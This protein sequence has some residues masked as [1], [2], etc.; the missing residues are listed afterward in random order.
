MIKC[1]RCNLWRWRL[2]IIR[3]SRIRIERAISGKSDGITTRPPTP[4]N[5]PLAAMH[6]VSQ[7]TECNFW[8]DPSRR[9][10]RPS[11]PI[12]HRRHRHQRYWQQNQVATSPWARPA[13]FHFRPQI[14]FQLGRSI[15]DEK[16]G[17]RM[18]VEK[19]SY[20]DFGVPVHQA[21]KSAPEFYFP[22]IRKQVTDQTA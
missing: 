9:S 11:Q 3:W 16:R 2:L 21:L 14:P 7:A 20:P 17:C 12:R 4:C 6:Y 22:D 1:R 5:A 13:K 19:L 10:R 8:A 18:R 15:K